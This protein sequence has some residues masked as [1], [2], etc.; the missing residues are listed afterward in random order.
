MLTDAE[1]ILQSQGLK[2]KVVTEVSDR[3]A[4]SVVRTDPD[5]GTVVPA[6]TAV[7]LYVA[8]PPASSAAPAPSTSTSRI[9]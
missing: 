9:P 1:Q 5:A 4:G 8:T 6:G 2:W 3:A 7:T